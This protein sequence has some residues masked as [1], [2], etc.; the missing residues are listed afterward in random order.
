M[1]ASGAIVFC[2]LVKSVRQPFYGVLARLSAGKRNRLPHKIHWYGSV[3][4]KPFISTANPA[5]L[6]FSRTVIYRS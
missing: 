4:R 5:H 6:G 2:Q 3:P 1:L